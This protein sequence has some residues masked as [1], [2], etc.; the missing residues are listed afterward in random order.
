[1]TIFNF[2]FRFAQ[3][4]DTSDIIQDREE[5]FQ[6]KRIGCMMNRKRVFA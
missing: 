3:V 1:M 5:L 4:V 6:T 2:P